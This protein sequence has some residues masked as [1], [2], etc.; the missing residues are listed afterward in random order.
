MA[1]VTSREPSGILS[2]STGVCEPCIRIGTRIIV[3]TVPQYGPYLGDPVRT[4]GVTSKKLRVGITELFPD[5]QLSPL[6][7]EIRCNESPSILVCYTRRKSGEN[8]ENHIQAVNVEVVLSL[9][10]PVR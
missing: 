8:R 3:R 7:V 5:Y 2:S 4:A 6:V 10:A 1:E 9:G